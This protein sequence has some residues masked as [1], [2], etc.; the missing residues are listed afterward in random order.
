MIRKLLNV[1]ILP[2]VGANIDAKSWIQKILLEERYRK[3][4]S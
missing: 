2:K 3:I 4:N 1:F